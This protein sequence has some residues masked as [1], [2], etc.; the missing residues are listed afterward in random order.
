MVIRALD[1]RRQKP[2]VRAWC[3]AVGPVASFMKCLALKE[4]Y[5]QVIRDICPDTLLAVSL[6]LLLCFSKNELC[7]MFVQVIVR[8]G[9]RN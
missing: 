8:D 5:I 3:I 2:L 4:N 6:R 7:H 9:V 1:D